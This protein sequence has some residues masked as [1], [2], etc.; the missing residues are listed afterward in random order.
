M[1]VD[2]EYRVTELTGM[3]GDQQLPSTRLFTRLTPVKPE[4]STR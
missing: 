4:V 1:M 3:E 2:Q